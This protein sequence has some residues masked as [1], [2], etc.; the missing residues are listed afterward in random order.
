MNQLQPTDVTFSTRKRKHMFRERSVI[1]SVIINNVFY[2]EILMVFKFL[3]S[4]CCFLGVSY[5]LYVVF[6]YVMELMQKLLLDINLRSF[7]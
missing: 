4:V 7:V 3:F 6:N 5:T 1:A 2:K